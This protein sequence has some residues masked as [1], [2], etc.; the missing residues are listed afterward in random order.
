MITVYLFSFMGGGHGMDGFEGRGMDWN[1]TSRKVEMDRCMEK[2]S[3]E[4]HTV[5]Y[6]TK[7]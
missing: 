2:E 5:F 4:E 3:G 6:V 7:E 1:C